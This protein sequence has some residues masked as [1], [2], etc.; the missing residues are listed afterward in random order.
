M[1]TRASAL[2]EALHL[3]LSANDAGLKESAEEAEPMEG[4][5]QVACSSCA[6]CV[7]R[8]S[9]TVYARTGQPS[10]PSL[11]GTEQKYWLP[12]LILRQGSTA[13]GPHSRPEWP[14][15]FHLPAERLPAC[16]A[17]ALVLP[18]GNRDKSLLAEVSSLVSQLKAGR[19]PDN[20]PQTF[21]RRLQAKYRPGKL[22]SLL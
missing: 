14:F 12:L 19:Q 8:R 5:E 3:L 7:C 21:L 13:E 22:M 6:Q 1:G 15:L 2:Q 4:P 20:R 9:S 11:Q 17:R 16:A 10:L 18:V